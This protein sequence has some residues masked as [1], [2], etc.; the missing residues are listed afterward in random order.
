ML[1]PADLFFCALLTC[2]SVGV[3]YC[4][5]K[6]LSVTPVNQLQRQLSVRFFP[7]WYFTWPRVGILARENRLVMNWYSFLGH[8]YKFLI[9]L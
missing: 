2:T 8:E 9:P 1:V 5:G 3:Q 6:Y 4:K 7:I